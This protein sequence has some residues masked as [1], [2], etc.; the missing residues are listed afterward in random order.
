VNLLIDKI[1]I[2]KAVKNSMVSMNNFILAVE[3]AVNDLIIHL[4][5]SHSQV[6]L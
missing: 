3:N 2:G 4:Y 1:S 5:G 6:K